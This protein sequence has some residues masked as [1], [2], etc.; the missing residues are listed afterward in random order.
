MTSNW[1][2][3]QKDDAALFIIQLNSTRRRANPRG[4]YENLVKSCNK[5]PNEPLNA[6]TCVD[7]PIKITSKLLFWASPSGG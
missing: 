6:L 3:V 5:A 7:Y 2:H 4:I 1:A